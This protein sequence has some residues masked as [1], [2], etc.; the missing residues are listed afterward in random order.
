[1]PWFNTSK[2]RPVAGPVVRRRVAVA[3][4]AVVPIR[5]V[6]AAE[7]CRV[8]YERTPQEGAGRAIEVSIN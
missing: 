1:M 7:R 5:G 8:P 3:Q 2:L 6:D 4:P